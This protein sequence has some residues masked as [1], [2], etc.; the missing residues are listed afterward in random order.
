MR[1]ES[2]EAPAVWTSAQWLEYFRA[3]A[4]RP[5][6][7]PWHQGVGASTEELALI[8]GSL[9]SWQLG[10]TSDGAHLFETAQRY[11]DSEGDPEF[12]EVARLFIAEEQ[13]HGEALGR[14][15]DLAGVP[16]AQRDFG[17]TL[18]RAA[19]H[20]LPGLEVWT[21]PVLMAEVHAM[22]YYN[23]IRK[24]TGSLVLRRICE[25]L[26]RDEVAHIRFQCERLAILHRRRPRWLRAL[27]MGGHHVLF[28]A[29]T[30]G[31]WAGHRKALRAGGYDFGH[32]W[33]SAWDRM[34]HAWRA[35]SP[36]AYQWEDASESV[37]V[38]GEPI[39]SV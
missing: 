36:D 15:L 39:G 2:K 27:T 12:V 20:C 30:L 1:R 14:F 6:D 13:G 11:A 37:E 8:V 24:A 32:F 16:R 35:L 29:V 28:L 18:F 23:A 22:V 7:C 9:R 17:D 26:L 10:E 3:N 21:T 38:G 31:I 19:R 5:L 25:R 33:R 34:K 4:D